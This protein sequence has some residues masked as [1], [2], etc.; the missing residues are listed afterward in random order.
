MLTPGE[1]KLYGMSG[2]VWL[3]EKE[4]EEVEDFHRQFGGQFV[5]TDTNNKG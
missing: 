1:R 3:T 2:L 4:R 5:I